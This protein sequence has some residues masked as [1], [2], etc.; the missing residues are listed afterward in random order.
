MQYGRVFD[1]ALAI[2]GVAMATA[3]LRSSNTASIIQAIGSGFATS[4]RAALGE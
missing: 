2:V 4:V 3:I 1:V